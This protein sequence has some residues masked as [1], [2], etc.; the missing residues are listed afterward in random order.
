[1]KYAA[2]LKEPPL[3]ALWTS[4]VLS[5]VGDQLYML[6]A[7]W[8]AV[9]RFGSQAGYVAAAIGIG[10]ITFGLFGGLIADRYNR[11]QV[12]ILSDTVRF[13]AVLP[14]P[15]I[16][17]GGTIELWHL[18]V[19]GAVMGAFGAFFDP[20]LQSALPTIASS[21]TVLEAMTGLMDLTQRLARAVGP[22]LTGALVAIMPITQFFT[23]EAISFL[24][25]ALTIL[26]L[27]SRLNW[28]QETVSKGAHFSLQDVMRDLS[29]GFSAAGKNRA[30]LY[31]LISLI[32]QAGFWGIAFTVGIPILVKQSF[33]DNVANYGYLVAAYGLGSVLGNVMCANLHIKNTW[34]NCFAAD[35]IC[36]LGFV[37]LA[38]SHNMQTAAICAVIA[39][40]GGA[41]GDLLMLNLIIKEVPSNVL[42][43]IMSLRMMVLSGGHALGLMVAAPIFKLGPA[44]SVIVGCGAI[45]LMFSVFGAMKYAKYSFS[46][47]ELV[48]EPQ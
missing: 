37:L 9:Q 10:R 4:Q 18:V 39:A 42:G 29:E 11:K 7:M 15:I 3:A 25:S 48:P 31:C 32:F 46:T 6:A 36:G 14:L 2:A 30:L 13:L 8:I 24:I 17:L 23:I 26:I 1:M 43:K 33:G 5:G 35:A 41:S 16:A 20:A 44:L 40:V 27:G 34:F 28:A 45:M 38:F 12:L 47:G 19:T 21:Q 22:S